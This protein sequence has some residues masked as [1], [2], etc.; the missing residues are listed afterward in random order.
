L[1][2]FYRLGPK[3]LRT[4]AKSQIAALFTTFREKA[5][6]ETRIQDGE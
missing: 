6:S 5:F 4:E 1:S 3:E 2:R